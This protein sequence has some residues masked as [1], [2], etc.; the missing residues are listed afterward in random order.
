M[1]KKDNFLSRVKNK[2][3]MTALISTALPKNGCKDVLL[4]GDADV[5][6]VQ[7]TVEPSRHS[8]T[9]LVDEDTYLLI[10]LLHY[11]EKDNSKLPL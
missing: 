2:I 3:G 10:F 4:P 11:S 9:T 8:T 1:L 7:T 5:D 6:I